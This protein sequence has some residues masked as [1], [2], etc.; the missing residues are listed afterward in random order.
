MYL[1]FKLLFID[2]VDSGHPNWSSVWRFHWEH[3]QRT[4]FDR[5]EWTT[6]VIGR[7][8]RQV[9]CLNHCKTKWKAFVVVQTKIP[10]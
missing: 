4:K 8:A 2:W 6:D 10:S 9:F 1:Q 7:H 3:R 5:H